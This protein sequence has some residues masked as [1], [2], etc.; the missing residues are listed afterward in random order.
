[1]RATSLV[2]ALL[3]WSVEAIAAEEKE[4]PVAYACKMETVLACVGNECSP[5]DDKWTVYFEPSTR[6][7]NYFSCPSDTIFLSLDRCDSSMSMKRQSIRKGRTTYQAFKE[8]EGETVFDVLF[9]GHFLRQIQTAPTLTAFSVGRC[10]SGEPIDPD[11]KS[12]FRR[13]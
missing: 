13:Q 4:A 3:L 11:R 9:N 2:L 5:R 10:Q 7:K 6:G 1:M 12:P 8:D